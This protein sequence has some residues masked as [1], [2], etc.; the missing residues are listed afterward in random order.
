MYLIEISPNAALVEGRKIRLANEPKLATNDNVELNDDS[1]GLIIT[2]PGVYK[3]K[4]LLT[5][6]SGDNGIGAGLRANGNELTTTEATFED[7]EM[8][9]III[10]YPIN[11]LHDGNGDNKVTIEFYASFDATLLGG[12]VMVE[13]VI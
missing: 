4:L 10:D 7:G 11:V 2:K 9:E 5:V 8:G 13:R 6:I 1:T 12:H 3:I